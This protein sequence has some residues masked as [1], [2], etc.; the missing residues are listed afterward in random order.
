MKTRIIPLLLIFL[1]IGA[2]NGKVPG[3]DA[4][5]IP[6]NAKDRIKK[7]NKGGSSVTV[8]GRC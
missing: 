4:R 3:A 1:L 8:I 7:K 2:C 6:P 5:K